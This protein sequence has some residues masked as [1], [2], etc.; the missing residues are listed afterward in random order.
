MRISLLLATPVL[1][2]AVAGCATT[3]DPPR[4]AWRITAHWN[5]GGSGGWDYLAVDAA[6]HRLFVTRSDHVAV[7]DIDIGKPLGEIRPT[8]GVHGVALAP[9]LNRGYASKGHGDSV[10]VFD[11]NTLATLATIPVGGHNPDAIVF[12]APTQRVFTFNGR[13]H[14]ATVI[15]AATNRPIA[16]IALAG[17][18]EFAVSDGDGR[19]YVNIEDRAELSAID[20]RAATVVATWPLPGCE[21]PSGLALDRAQARLFSVC[22]NGRLVVTDAA[23][24]RHVAQV[25]IGSGPDAAGFD[26]RRHLVFSS[27]GADGSLTV[28]GQRDADHYTVLDTLATQK[29]ARTFALDPLSH[30]VFLAAA[31]FGPAPAAVAGQPG[32]R[33]P[34]TPDSFTILVA[35]DRSRHAQGG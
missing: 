22:R 8:D 7:I 3:A 1:A 31:Q 35:S 28:I 14:D 26:E 15:D 27:N 30:R 9:A 2:L 19:I 10:S 34:M 25:P 4:E 12:D 29:S 17:K 23:N 24:G 33:P 13:S 6:T 16:T 5:L 20:T 11:L 21:E 18:P 32:R